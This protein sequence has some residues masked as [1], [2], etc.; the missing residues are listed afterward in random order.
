[1]SV[2]SGPAVCR[3][4]RAG[5]CRFGGSDSALGLPGCWACTSGQ[6]GAASC[7]CRAVRWT[8]V[9][10]SARPPTES[11]AAAASDPNAI[12]PGGVIKRHIRGIDSGARPQLA[13]GWNVGRGGRRWQRRPAGS[14]F[15]EATG[16]QTRSHDGVP[17]LRMARR[18][19]ARSSVVPALVCL[20]VWSRVRSEPRRRRAG[21]PPVAGVRRRAPGRGLGDHR[22]SAGRRL[23]RCRVRGGHCRGLWRPR[24]DGSPGCSGRWARG[25]SASPSPG[26]C[27]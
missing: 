10:A 15:H 5:V 11:R 16:S 27:T 4:S 3:R 26:R 13:S 8:Q 9:S 18:A 19:R 20:R 21:R 24:R 17:W 25:S 1:M 2:L 6:A 12:A 7:C 22:G 14:R 23:P